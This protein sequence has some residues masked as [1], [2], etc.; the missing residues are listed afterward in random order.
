MLPRVKIDFDNGALESVVPTADGTFGLIAHADEV[1]FNSVKTFELNKAY[2]LKRTKD[3]AKLGIVSGA[4]NHR[5]Y[6]T[7]TEF[8][9]E[10]GEGTELW[11]MGMAKA[12]KVS[13]WFKPVAGVTPAE[14]LLD[15]AKGKLR[16]ILTSFTAPTGFTPTLVNGLDT[17]VM[18]AASHAQ[19]LAENYTAKKY[20]PFMVFLEGVGFD[21]N[22]GTL[23]DLNQSGFNRVGIL[24]GDT[25]PKTAANGDTHYGAA[26]GVLAG[27]A[28]KVQV[29][30]N[31]ARV[32]DG[33]TSNL[34][35]FV[36][37]E[38]AE[39]FDGE[40]LHDKGFITFRFHQGKAG[41]FFTDDPLATSFED[42]YKYITRRRTIDKA[43]RIAYG[44]L[45]NYLL[46]EVPVTGDGTVS[47]PFL[48][49]MESDVEST[50]AGSMTANGELSADVNDKDDKGVI[51]FIDPN[52]KIVANSTL[53]V[54]VRVRPHGYARFIDVLLGFQFQTA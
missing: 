30:V 7:V 42:D 12:T 14:T 5:L 54:V 8:Y 34:K 28:A 29:H 13:D 19:T 22:V 15:T 24:I 11:L 16:A 35:A 6:K 33:A 26:I 39:L 40:S 44:T 20:A 21:G 45:V 10:A 53:E 25:E 1:T 38:P 46:E 51:C 31:I 43:F 23:A 50:I 48:K 36:L 49:A 27:R 9:R 2:V 4:G 37:D 32:R 47:R 41:Y 52:Q 18:E 3:L 17:D